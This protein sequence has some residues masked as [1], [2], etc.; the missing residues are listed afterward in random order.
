MFFEELL[1]NM[2]CWFKGLYGH[3]LSEHL[4]GW[5]DGTGDYTGILV[6]NSVGLWTLVI[7]AIVMVLYYYVIDHPRFCKWWHWG[8]MAAG[9]SLIALL[10]GWYRAFSDY[11]NGLIANSLMYAMDENGEEVQ[12]ITNSNCWGFGMANMI[13]A[14]IFFLVL[15]MLFKW[16]S[17]NAKKSPFG[18]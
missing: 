5:E 3:N 10:V 18:I 14:F 11:N 15:S 13:V 7:S 2:Y 4:W 12:L 6:Y 16:W 9:N 17:K 8:I 1:G